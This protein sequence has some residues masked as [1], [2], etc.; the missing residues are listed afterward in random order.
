AFSVSYSRVHQDPERD[1]LYDNRK[2]AYDSHPFGSGDLVPAEMISYQAAVKHV[3]DPRWT[4]QWGL[5][6]RDGYAQPGA[7]NRSTNPAGVRLAYDIAD[8]GHAAG[9]E[10]ALHFDSGSG[11]HVEL[12]YTYADSWGTQSSPQGLDFGPPTGQRPLPT[13]IHPLDWDQR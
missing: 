11:Q 1:L 12:S 7:R 6:Y 5:F 9:S 3:L 4:V 10:L 13:Q 8:D 2:V